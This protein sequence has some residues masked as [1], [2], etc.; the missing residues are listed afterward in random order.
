[1]SF[2]LHNLGL[3]LGGGRVFVAVLPQFWEGVTLQVG[4]D[5]RISV[6]TDR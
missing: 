2:M 1:M 6:W 3:L 5:S 4:V